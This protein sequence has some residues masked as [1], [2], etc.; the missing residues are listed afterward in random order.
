MS[1]F[2]KILP[3]EPEML[4]LP[5]NEID[6]ES[7][8]EQLSSDNPDSIENDLKLL[9]DEKEAKETEEGTIEEK[10]TQEQEEPK[11]AQPEKSAEEILDELLKTNPDLVRAKINRYEKALHVPEEAKPKP[12]SSWE[13]VPKE[14]KETL[15]NNGLMAWAKNL[16]DRQDFIDDRFNQVE[17]SEIFIQAVEDQQRVKEYAKEQ[18]G[19]TLTA[20][21]IVGLEVSS[22][23]NGTDLKTE[24]HRQFTD[25]IVKAKVAAAEKARRQDIIKKIP[26]GHSGYG[27]GSMKQDAGYGLTSAELTVAKA[28]GLSPAEYSRYKVRSNK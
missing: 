10:Q 9:A 4:G 11:Q 23:T 14:I 12:V 25:H 6:V 1:D 19:R 3:D 28:A 20:D 13:G 27:N 16:H 5:E 26:A 17:A 24:F 15:E 8:D 22:A 18:I 21:E 2:E 7:A